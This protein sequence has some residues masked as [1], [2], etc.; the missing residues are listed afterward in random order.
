MYAEFYK[1]WATAKESIKNHPVNKKSSEM[2]PELNNKFYEMSLLVMSD[3]KISKAEAQKCKEIWDEVMEYY[4]EEIAPPYFKK[5][6]SMFGELVESLK[7]AP[8]SDDE[9][10]DQEDSSDESEE[11]KYVVLEINCLVPENIAENLQSFVEQHMSDRN[12]VSL[13]A[14]MMQQHK[15][16][17]KKPVKAY[18]QPAL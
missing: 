2:P 6:Q 1:L 13:A 10:D 11:V 16:E 12:K 15:A 4:G 8:M 18:I 5:I 9:D 7:G 3:N 17:M 14:W